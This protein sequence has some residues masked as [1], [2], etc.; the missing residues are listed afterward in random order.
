MVDGRYGRGSED[1]NMVY[2]LGKIVQID[3]LEEKFY[4]FYCRIRSYL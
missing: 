2:G 1:R 4:E 3:S